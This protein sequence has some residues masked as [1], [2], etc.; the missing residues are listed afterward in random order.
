M[1]LHR[2]IIL[3]ITCLI[4]VNIEGQ[5]FR[6]LGLGTNLGTRKGNYSQPRM[7][8]EGNS[9]YVCTNQGLYSKNLAEDSS[10]WQCTGFNGIPLQDYV[11]LG[12]DILALQYNEGG[13][14][15]L[16]SHDGGQTYEDVTP[17][18]FLKEKYDILPSIAQAPKDSATLLVSSIYW[19]IFRSI[20]F[21]RTWECLTEY[22]YG[23]GIVSFI[24][25]HPMQPNVIFNSGEG[26]SLEGHINISYD[27]G[28]T[29][30]DHD[31][32]L[33]F[34][35]ENCVHRPSFNPHNPHHWI[36][37]GEGCIFISTDNGQTWNHQN[38]GTDEGR[39]AYW[40]YSAFD[41]I[42]PET[43]YVA[44]NTKGNMAAVKVMCSTDGG[45]TWSIPQT[46]Q[47]DNPSIGIVNDLQQYGGNLL[48]Y[49]EQ[50][51]FIVSKTDLLKQSFASV[52]VITTIE[53]DSNAIYDLQ[54]RR[55][56]AEPERGL[57]IK[58]GKKIAR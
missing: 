2:I 3:S 17:E 10:E 12:N 4:S 7:H 43:I 44:G 5:L 34:P 42:N 47:N 23:N 49:T 52:H 41:E 33:G 14:F 20:D 11:R 35:G 57:Y 45:K 40:Y 51:I 32:S 38:Y 39:N 30:N 24:G 22:L 53:D 29:W 50:D 9:L 36:A 46:I 56:N 27:G 13:G 48:I 25:F 58:D 28:H 16:L 31:E 6:S 19:G 18:I 37:G 55:L 26:D 21:G 54:G 15:L 8:I 1:K